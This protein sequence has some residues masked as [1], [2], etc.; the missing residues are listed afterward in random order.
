MQKIFIV[1]MSAIF[2]IVGFACSHIEPSATVKLT[3]G[4]DLSAG[5]DMSYII[6]TPAATYYLEKQGGGL[7]SIVD[8]DGIDWLGFN[9]AAGTA[10]KGEYRGFP[11]AIHKQDGSY[12]HAMNQYTD[13]SSSVVQIE[14][15]NHVRILFTASNGKWQGQ[16]D[17]YPDRCDFS[18]TSVSSGHQYWVQYEGVP[19]GHMDDTDYWFSS[20]DRQKRRVTEP[21]TGDLPKPEWMA[22]GD[23][24]SARVLFMLHHQDDNYPDNYEHRPD[25]TVFAFGRQQKNKYLNTPQR[26]SIGFIESTQYSNIA[27]QIKAV[28]D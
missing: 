11:N 22:F 23:T 8:K 24:Q 4:P 1:Y 10:H 9:K 25:M 26:F 19:G 21:Y 20:A 14:R 7:S 13:P 6:T 28:L 18:M 17:F 12:F 3:H 2:A 5:G 27:G 15:N 16:W